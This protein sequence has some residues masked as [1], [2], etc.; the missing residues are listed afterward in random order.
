MVNRKTKQQ[1]ELDFTR[2]SDQAA[3]IERLAEDLSRVAN[4]G[5]EPAILVL[6][7]CWRGDAGGSIELAGRGTIEEIYR[8]AD[9]LM[10]V[11]RS[12]RQTADIV[13][14]AEIAAAGLCF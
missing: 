12:I 8:T 14:R 4:S 13:Y 3:E 9:T 5:V 10:R 6:K 7:N 11:A 2:A 1:I